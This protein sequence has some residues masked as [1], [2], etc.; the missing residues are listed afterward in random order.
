MPCQCQDL[1]GNAKHAN[2]REHHEA[3]AQ[4][5]GLGL[6]GAGRSILSGEGNFHLH[7]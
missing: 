6:E 4:P 3:T 5:Q 7:P 2:L 1:N